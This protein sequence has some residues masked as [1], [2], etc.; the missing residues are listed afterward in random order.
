MDKDGAVWNQSLYLWKKWDMVMFGIA[1]SSLLWN[2]GWKFKT[3]CIENIAG[4][5]KVYSLCMYEA[6]LCILINI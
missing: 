6:C 2:V 5:E 1:R 4:M 3:D